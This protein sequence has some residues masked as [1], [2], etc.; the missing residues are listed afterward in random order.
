MSLKNELQELLQKYSLPVPDYQREDSTGPS[1]SPRFKY[2]VTVI[3][4]DE[5]VLVERAEGKRVK[6]AE[7]NAAKV[8][9]QR[10]KNMDSEIKVR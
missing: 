7:Q 8:M 6:E 10:I 2:R 3:W 5:Q 1:H 9:L 4:K